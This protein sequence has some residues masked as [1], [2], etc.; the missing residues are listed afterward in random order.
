[1]TESAV[2]P[3]AHHVD[4]HAFDPSWDEIDVAL[5]LRS[6]TRNVPESEGL[7]LID[8]ARDGMTVADWRTAADA[9]L[10][11][12]DASYR[13]TLIRL[14]QRMF[15]DVES[16][17]IVETPF[18]R[19]IQDG[20]A[21][22]RHDL[23]FARYALAHP[24]TLL[25]ARQLVLPGLLTSGEGA[26]VSSEDWDA[27]VARFI[28]DKASDASRRKTRSTVI[29]TLMQLGVLERDG[30]SS[31]PTRLRRGQPAALAFAWA[32]CDQ[33]VGELRPREHLDWATH[34]SDAAQLFA[35]LP[36]DAED[37]LGHALAEDELL[38]I[39]V[40]GEPGVSPPA[41]YGYAPLAN[42]DIGEE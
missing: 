22:Q 20:D 40:G 7:I 21:E 25:A 28:E 10:P 29:G 19:L 18:L 38:A 1:M 34:R 12:G 37:L 6:W 32:V 27:F 33:M 35:I 13:Q 2:G 16:D 4:P 23:F 14:V 3:G 41:S 17:A 11:H 8:L 30:S 26:T 9:A 42:E 5:P 39:E 31:S 36:E 15:L 24:W